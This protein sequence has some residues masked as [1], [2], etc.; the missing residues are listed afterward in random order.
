MNLRA[1]RIAQP[2]SLL[3]R[4]LKDERSV[5]DDRCH[6]GCKPLSRKFARYVFQ[7]FHIRV[8]CS[9]RNAANRP[10]CIRQQTWVEVGYVSNGQCCRGMGARRS[11]SAQPSPIRAVF[12]G[13]SRNCKDAFKT[14]I[15]FLSNS[16]FSVR[17]RISV[18]VAR[19]IDGLGK[20]TFGQRVV[21][22]H[23]F[24]PSLRKGRDQ[25][26]KESLINRIVRP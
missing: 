14:L 6:Q 17:L 3:V 7:Y 22:H 8:R 5:T 15:C 23:R 10:V 1:G 12:E 20:W 21:E 11:H 18:T 13:C 26:V 16:L 9:S 25:L 24:R 19:Q 4:I 2:V